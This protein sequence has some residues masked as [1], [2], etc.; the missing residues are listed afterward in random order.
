MSSGDNLKFLPATRLSSPSNFLCFANNYSHLLNCIIFF[1][2]N[3]FL[4]GFYGLLQTIILSNVIES[5]VSVILG[6]DIVPLSIW[7]LT[8]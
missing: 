1:F 3:A 2:L 4:L 6:Y 7:F 8:F 5:D